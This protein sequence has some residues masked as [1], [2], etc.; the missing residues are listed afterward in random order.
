VNGDLPEVLTLLH[1]S[2]QR[3]RT[4][5]AEGEEWRDERRS[6]EVFARLRRPGSVVAM[7]GSPGPAERDPRWRFW[8]RQPDQARVEYGG[9]H[10][11]RFS[12]ITDGHRRW[13]SLPDGRAM[14]E[15]RQE[16]PRL[17]LGPV[18]V[19]VETAAVPAALVLD[20]SG[21][22]RLL[23]RETLSVRGRAQD[24]DVRPGP[25]PFH[26]F[27]RVADE[28]RL[29]V[30]RERGIILRLE[31]LLDGSPFHRLE[32]TE[33]AFDETL[34]EDVFV[35]PA[36]ETVIEYRPGDRRRE[37]PP[38]MRPPRPHHPGPPED[39][40]G[41]PAPLEAVLARTPAVV[42][43]VDRVVA[44]PTGFELHLTVRTGDQRAPGTVERGHPRSW[45][46][47]WAFPGESLRFGVAFSD[48][49]AA[50]A[51]NFRDLPSADGLTLLP[52]S[53]S[54]T[55]GRFDQ[56]F[57]VEPLPPPGPLGLVV[58]WPVHG[59]AETRVDVSADA[60]LDA[61]SRAAVLWTTES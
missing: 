16:G 44:Y 17:Q 34:P 26:P 8:I 35:F 14:V 33:V 22:N 3:W 7:R 23:G 9:A 43:A 13:F 28:V 61:A 20:V 10:Q 39:V 53:G 50:F 6:H 5:R 25:G 29:E 47:S 60:I 45:G 55:S 54:G 30:D 1:T 4:L 31:A 12:Q 56:R 37:P 15:E 40:L 48:G 59:L 46:G 58:H 32:M 24:V 18:D 51:S 42:V 21:R 11:T 41:A 2:R 19:L 49:R 57:W 36:D 38:Q 27:L 52:I